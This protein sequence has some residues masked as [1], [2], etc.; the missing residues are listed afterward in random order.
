MSVF[1]L[2]V[3]VIQCFEGKCQ[4]VI[5]YWL[6]CHR[7][8]QRDKWELWSKVT[9]EKSLV[10]VCGETMILIIHNFISSRT[11]DSGKTVSVHANVYSAQHISEIQCACVWCCAGHISDMPARIK[12]L[13]TTERAKA[14]QCAPPNQSCV[15]AQFSLVLDQ[16][17]NK[18]ASKCWSFVFSPLSYWF[19]W[20]VFIGRQWNIGRIK[21][22][23]F[24]LTS[25]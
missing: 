17:T 15:K 10:F 22:R 5:I 7:V 12:D 20:L 4:P 19:D 14:P 13:F 6:I 8:A 21:G 24:T 3:F 18:T 25:R 9:F 23:A 16:N 2:D 11:F 1:S